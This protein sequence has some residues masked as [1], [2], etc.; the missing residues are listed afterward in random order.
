MQTVQL[1]TVKKVKPVFEIMYARKMCEIMENYVKTMNLSEANGKNG[2]NCKS[3][4][5]ECLDSSYRKCLTVSNAIFSI[6]SIFTEITSLQ[7]L[8][9]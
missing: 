1:G 9:K 3:T 7:A 5:I 8:A 4:V 2:K 6:S